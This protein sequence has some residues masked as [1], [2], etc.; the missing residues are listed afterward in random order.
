MPSLE[1]VGFERVEVKR[2]KTGT[3]KTELDACKR[4]SVADGEGKRKVVIGQHTLLVG[5]S[6]ERQVKHHF[7][8]RLAQSE[9]EGGGAFLV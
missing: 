9:G 8:I 7:N 3:A 2:G 6:S 5:S 4:L 1:L